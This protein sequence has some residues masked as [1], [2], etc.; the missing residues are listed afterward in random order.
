MYVFDLD[1]FFEL[2]NIMSITR[3]LEEHLDTSH[4]SR[5]LTMFVLGRKI[6]SYIIRGSTNFYSRLLNYPKLIEKVLAQLI[7]Q[8]F[9][10]E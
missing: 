8:E 4:N 3:V 7:Q 2:R 5:C 6:H 1:F 9:W 10:V